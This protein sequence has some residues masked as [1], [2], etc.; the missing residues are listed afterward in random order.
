MKKIYTTLF[1]SMIA[2]FVFAQSARKTY[3]LTAVSLPQSVSKGEH[4]FAIDTLWPPSFSPNVL[5]CDTHLV[6]YKLQAPNTGYAFGNNSIGET[7]CA[8]KYSA[9]GTVSKV[10]VLYGKKI[11]SAGTTSAKL[12]SIDAVK[13]GPSGTVLGTSAVVTIGSMPS[14]GFVDYT[15]SAPVTVSG[16]F[17]ASIVF[18]TTAGDSVAL[19]STLIGCA[20]TDSLSWL[21][22]A[23][24]WGSINDLF[25]SNA[26]LCIFPVANTN[27]GVAELPSSMGLTLLGSSPNPASELATIKFTLDHST[28]VS[29]IIFDQSGRVI[30]K[31]NY[32]ANSGTHSASVDLR[33]LA[34]GTYYYSIK[35]N[36]T[37]LT[38]QFSV[39][40]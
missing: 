40:K 15:F 11:G 33:D 4:P 34:S 23:S 28:S 6:Y 19:A 20:T 10:I 24:V 39:V 38:S 29:M 25:G 35:T 17:A 36:E 13:K 18:P 7:E 9:T 16:G 3:P 14:T 8:Q 26:E 30:K 31:Y 1:L 12:Y 5:M 21:S 37:M 27:S 32:Q 22:V 2:L